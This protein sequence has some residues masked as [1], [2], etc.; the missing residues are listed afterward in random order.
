MDKFCFSVVKNK[1]IFY[2]PAFNILDAFLNTMQSFIS[3]F[4]IKSKEQLGVVSVNNCANSMACDDILKWGTVEC[5]Q[6]GSSNRALG[7]SGMALSE[8]ESPMTTDCVRS[9]KYDLNHSKA[10]PVIPYLDDKRRCK[11]A[12][13]IVSNALEK[14]SNTRRASL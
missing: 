3:I 9:F 2:C 1:F 5:E 14:S 8:G 7:N 6:Q 12:W 10:F 11:I 4:R 13:S